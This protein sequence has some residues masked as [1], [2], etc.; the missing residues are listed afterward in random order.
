MSQQVPEVDIDHVPLELAETTVVLD[1]RE[2]DEWQA[3][4]VDG[5]VHVPLGQLP[6]RLGELSAAQRVLVVCKAGGR[7][8]KATA[9]LTAQGVDAVNLRGGMLAWQHAQRAMVSDSGAGPQVI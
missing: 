3:G 6:Q 4:H 9:F 7:S 5:A 8:A 1:V 2:D